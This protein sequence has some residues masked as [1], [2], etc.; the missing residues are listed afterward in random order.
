M[1]NW[2]STRSS[3]YSRLLAPRRPAWEW[4]SAPAWNGFKNSHK[5]SRRF[6]NQ[7]HEQE[8]TS[9]DR[10]KMTFRMPEMTIVDSKNADVTCDVLFDRISRL[11]NISNRNVIYQTV[12]LSTNDYRAI[13]SKTVSV[14]CNSCPLPLGGI[15][16]P[17]TWDH[18]RR[19]LFT[20]VFENSA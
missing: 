20:D 18:Q 12:A 13:R 11:R 6:L 4:E 19:T 15:Q 14:Q 5:W 17:I 2:P 9:F 7:T 8:V 1:M 16:L 3:S 10:G